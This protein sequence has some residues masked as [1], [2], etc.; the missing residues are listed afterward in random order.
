[1]L[2]VSP[3]KRTCLIGMWY[4]YLITFM[5]FL[6][7]TSTI[8]TKEIAKNYE[9]VCCLKNRPSSLNSATEPS[10]I[11]VDNPTFWCN[12]VSLK[13]AS[14]RLSIIYNMRPAY[15][16]NIIM[17]A[18]VRMSKSNDIA[19]K[20]V[21]WNLHPVRVHGMLAVIVDKLT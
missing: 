9:K 8:N 6:L 21:S 17:N 4:M 12:A 5:L 7:S 3:V 16:I 2:N 10:L 19:C 14:L 11:R 1:M 18:N 13:K 20:N 15:F